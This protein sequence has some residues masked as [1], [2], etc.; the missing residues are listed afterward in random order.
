MTV[1]DKVAE[2]IQKDVELL[3]AEQDKWTTLPTAMEVPPVLVILGQ[4]ARD[5]AVEEVT[6]LIDAEQFERAHVEH[7]N[8]F[9]TALAFGMHLGQLGYTY[10]SFTPFP[11]MTLSDEDIRRLLNGNAE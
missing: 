7:A 2:A 1:D 8:Y 5:A 10:K 4:M 9:I 3:K 6:K 11:G